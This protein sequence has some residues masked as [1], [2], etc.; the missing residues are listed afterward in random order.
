MD[1]I[2]RILAV[3]DEPS[4]LRLLEIGLRQAGYQPLVAS[5][6]KEALGIIKN[7]HVDLVVSDLHMPIMSGIE[8]LKVIHAEYIHLPFI[9][10]TAKGEIKTAVEAMRL[11]AEDY[12]LRPFD[13]ETLELAISKAL[14]SQ[15]MTIENAYL[16]EEKQSIELL[17]G[18]SLVMQQLKQQI[19]QVAP[20]KATVLITGET[21]TGKE[22][23]AKSLHLQSSAQ[24]NL[25]VAVNCAAIPADML[26]SELFGHEKGAFTGAAKERIGKFELADDGTLFLDEITEMPMH[27]QAKLLRALQEGVIEKLG[28]N[29]Q[30]HLNLRVIA[31]SNRN[32]LEAI[33]DGR[34]REDLYYR[35]NVFA[36][37]APALKERVDD[38]PLLA[39]YF[40][41][42]H[43]VSID[44]GAIASLNIYAWPGNIRELQNVI[45]RAAIICKNKTISMHDLPTDIIADSNP[46]ENLQQHTSTLS[47]LSIPKTTALIEKDLIVKALAT[48]DGNKAKAS[49]LL[50]I[51]ERSL[52][53]KLKLY[54]LQG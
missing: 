43:A 35:L 24:K 15:R 48:T 9:M 50:E 42:Q 1:K 54:K 44:D 2:K 17:I 51:S 49:K 28:G 53:N 22:L 25:F 40:A 7:Q 29:R 47:I 8:L 52:W 26:E 19:G 21:G 14:F 33:K 3:D 12:I 41:K 36:I 31:A 38:I 23:I 5:N 10:V 46:H 37:H 20:T 6:G 45:A 18:D 16:K 27:L 13:L 4:M 34:L 39:Q 32:A 11:G 30:I